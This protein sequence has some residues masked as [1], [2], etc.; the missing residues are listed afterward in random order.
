MKNK[1]K[2]SV[3]I[4]AAICCAV[5]SGTAVYAEDYPVK[6]GSSPS[7]SS[8]EDKSIW[9]EAKEIAG[10][11]YN[12]KYI[13]WVKK[14]SEKEQK[15]TVSFGKSRTKKVY[16]NFYKACSKEEVQ[17]KFNIINK[18]EIKSIAIKDDNV[19]VVMYTGGS[20]EALY[21]NPQKIT[22]LDID[23]KEKLVMSVTDEDYDDM[24]LN[25]DDLASEMKDEDFGINDD[26]K[27]KVFKFKNNNKIY[28]YEEFETDD[29]GGTLGFLFTEKGTPLAINEDG[30]TACFRMYYKVDDSEFD[31]PKGYK[32]VDY[33]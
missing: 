2:I 7:S 11:S 26:T 31:I 3:L 21:S 10:A 30:E 8:S 29:Y 14:Y 9:D 4:A 22:M 28:Y 32:T 19:K 33:D 24:G 27:G 18:T 16:E 1:K 15:N 25:A 5:L 13:K 23:E 6:A 17:V 20:A 12:S